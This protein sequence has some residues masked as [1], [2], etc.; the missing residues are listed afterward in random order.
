MS[1][2]AVPIPMELDDGDEDDKLKLTWGLTA[3]AAWSC[4]F[5]HTNVTICWSTVK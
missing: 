1:D 2:T 4:V 5:N 3:K